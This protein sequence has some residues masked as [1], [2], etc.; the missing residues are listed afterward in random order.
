M[1]GL[2]PTQKTDFKPFTPYVLGIIKRLGSRDIDTIILTSQGFK[3]IL[4]A[5]IEFLK[6]LNERIDLTLQSY[7]IIEDEEFP[8]DFLNLINNL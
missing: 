4:N 5:Y 6:F 3:V 7:S 2:N 1:F 8:K